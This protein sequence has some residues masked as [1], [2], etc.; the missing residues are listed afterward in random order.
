M[1]NPDFLKNSNKACTSNLNKMDCRRF[2]G[3]ITEEEVYISE[4][5]RRLRS[6]G[7]IVKKKLAEIPSP[8]SQSDN[9]STE[10]LREALQR[11]L[12]EI[13]SERK[14]L[15]D[16]RDKAQHRKMALLGHVDS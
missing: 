1:H 10:I 2:K 11:E 9:E 7:L 3:I 5:M 13:R 6:R 4:K 8:T 16:S 12:E 15:N 14:E